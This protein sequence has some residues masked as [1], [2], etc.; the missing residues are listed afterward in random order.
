MKKK[1]EPT[2]E[3]H[4]PKVERILT[5]AEI[6]RI[7]GTLRDD[8]GSPADAR[9]LL[10][11]FVHGCYCASGPSPELLIYLRDALSDFLYGGKTLD[12]ALHFKKGRGRPKIDRA[13]KVELA[14]A[15][16]RHR[17][18][19]GS[20]L[21][22]A[23]EHVEDECGLKRT[24][25]AGAW[26]ECKENARIRI[27]DQRMELLERDESAGSDLWTVEE[28]ATLRDIFGETLRMPEMV[29]SDRYVAVERPDAETPKLDS[30]SIARRIIEAGRR[31]FGK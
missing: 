10:E 8:R 24:V 6:H 26:S 15:V 31:A 14:T 18:R 9:L 27:R 28:I 2:L 11:Q 17:L 16:L 20:S 12:A 29:D 13:V 30:S 23:V 25:I 22:V 4:K 1:P 21:E 19:T 3:Y 5:D 7:A